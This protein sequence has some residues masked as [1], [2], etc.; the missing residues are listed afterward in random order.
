MLAGPPARVEEWKGLAAHHWLYPGPTA[1]RLPPGNPES[2]S[3]PKAQV[4]P[5]A[6]YPQLPEQTGSRPPQV[7]F[8]APPQTQDIL[9]GTDEGSKETQMYSQAPSRAEL[10][11]IDRSTPGAPL[12]R[13]QG[14]G[15][16]SWTTP[17]PTSCK[18]TGLSRPLK[19]D[20]FPA[21]EPLQTGKGDLRSSPQASLGT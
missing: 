7:L 14:H 4:D 2:Q 15:L 17:L 6:G 18:V 8:P 12:P 10:R 16:P 13:C 1:F 5:G 20:L 19:L 9:K 3:D 11:R 21:L